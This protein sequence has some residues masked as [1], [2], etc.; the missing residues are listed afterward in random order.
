MKDKESQIETYNNTNG[1]VGGL[2]LITRISSYRLFY[3]RQDS[4]DRKIIGHEGFGVC[5][6]NGVG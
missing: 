4:L 6:L 1:A 2:F 3:T 5:A